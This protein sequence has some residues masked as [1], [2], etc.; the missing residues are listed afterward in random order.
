[1]KTIT[2]LQNSLEKE[3]DEDNNN[4]TN[5]TEKK[6]DYLININYK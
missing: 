3:N 4:P 6:N 2:I 1:M 5:L